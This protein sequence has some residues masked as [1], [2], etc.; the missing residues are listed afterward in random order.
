[1]PVISINNRLLSHSQSNPD[2]TVSL[3]VRATNVETTWKTSW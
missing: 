2:T 1:L 3:T